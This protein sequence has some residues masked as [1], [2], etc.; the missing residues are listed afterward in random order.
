MNRYTVQLDHPDAPRVTLDIEAPDSVLLIPLLR[1]FL[2][3]E[4]QQDVRVY[5]NLE[6]SRQQQLYLGP[7]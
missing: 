6:N 5:I 3:T 4:Y 2:K 7:L 1:T